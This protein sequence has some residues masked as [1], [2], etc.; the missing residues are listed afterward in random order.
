MSGIQLKWHLTWGA[1]AKAFAE[2]L[3]MLEFRSKL[4]ATASG[5][6]MR[7]SVICKWTAAHLPIHKAKPLY[8][9]SAHIKQGG[10]HWARLLA[11]T[12]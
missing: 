7:H 11:P 4:N 1:E 6:N 2:K 10:L 8:P 9:D 3:K 12:W 5:Y